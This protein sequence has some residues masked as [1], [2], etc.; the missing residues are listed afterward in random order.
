MQHGW[1]SGG[2]KIDPRWYFVKSPIF[3]QGIWKPISIGNSFAFSFLC[4]WKGTLYCSA[5]ASSPV[6]AVH[7]HWDQHGSCDKRKHDTMSIYVAPTNKN[8]LWLFSQKRLKIY[9]LGLPLLIYEGK[10]TSIRNH[11]RWATSR[12]STSKL[13]SDGSRKLSCCFCWCSAWRLERDNLAQLLPGTLP[14]VLEPR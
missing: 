3:Q 7:S 1:K 12:A 9:K 11:L 8:T 10:A 13:F 5:R 6:L 14:Q 2:S 4:I